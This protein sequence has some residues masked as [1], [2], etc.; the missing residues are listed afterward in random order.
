[1][2]GLLVVA[3]LVAVTVLCRTDRIPAGASVIDDEVLV[4]SSEL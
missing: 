4:L 1:L 2:A 3:V